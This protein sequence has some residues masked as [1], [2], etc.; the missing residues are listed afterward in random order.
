[1]ERNHPGPSSLA[2]IKDMIQRPKLYKCLKNLRDKACDLYEDVSYELIQE[3]FWPSLQHL[4]SCQRDI[5]VDALIVNLSDR[6]LSKKYGIKMGT[7]H[8]LK[9]KGK[10]K[11]NYFIFSHLEAERMISSIKKRRLSSGK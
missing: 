2:I 3:L 5:I 8:S 6:E 7:V 1:M 9:K 10:K 4:T 11:L